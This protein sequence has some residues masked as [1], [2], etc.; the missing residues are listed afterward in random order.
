MSL[1]QASRDVLVLQI[2]VFTKLEFQ[3]YL[4]CDSNDMRVVETEDEHRL[5]DGRSSRN[6]Q[7]PNLPNLNDC[8]RE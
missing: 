1:V 3:A 5:P 7:I 2:D 8:I 6:V 4:L